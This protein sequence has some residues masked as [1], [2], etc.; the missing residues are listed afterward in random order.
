MAREAIDEETRE[1][2]QF[3][4]SKIFDQVQTSTSNHRK[5]HVALYKLHIELAAIKKSIKNGTQESLI[6]E[7]LFRKIVHD[8]LTRTFPHKKGV[9]C[10]DRVI[11]FVGSYVRF[12]NERGDRHVYC[13]AQKLTIYQLLKSVTHKKM[14]KKRTK[15]MKM[16]MKRL[17]SQGSP[18]SFWTF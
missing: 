3:S 18:Q 13:I 2:F 7:T 11:K 12:I 16:R 8:L 5:N 10:A 1:N 4:I 9:V 15:K 14:K 6:G 17:T